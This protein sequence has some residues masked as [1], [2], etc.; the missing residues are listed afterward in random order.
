LPVSSSSLK[1]LPK[2]LACRDADDSSNIAKTGLGSSATLVTSLVAALLQYFDVI[3]VSLSESSSE[4][5]R[6]V[7]N[8]AQ[9]AHCSA[10]GK[11]GS[12]FDVAAAVYGS[13]IYSRFDPEV[14]SNIVLHDSKEEDGGETTNII[15]ETVMSQSLWTQSINTLALPPGLDLVL[16]D[17]CGGS[18]SPSMARAVLQW[19]KSGG[20]I[21]EE[22]WSTLG[23][24]NQQLAVKFASFS[25]W[26]LSNESAYTR[27]IHFLSEQTSNRWI[28]CEEVHTNCLDFLLAIR[29]LFS[30]IRL[31]MKEMGELAGVEIE[32]DSQTEIIDA[33]VTIPGVIAAGVPGAGGNDAL[34]ALVLSESAR[35]RVENVWT[36]NNEKSICP[37]LF[38]TRESIAGFPGVRIENESLT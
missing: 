4:D 10:Q 23:S 19:R 5:L 38:T 37:L 35:I 15:H 21:A 8:L 13:M 33:T 25:T 24:L 17:V 20:T 34:F 16:G 29:N 32:P 2:F 9:L 1:L 12:G 26:A 30:S 31:K 27:T 36:S 14:L 6:I 3:H 28:P 22:L 18:N 7:H 11:I